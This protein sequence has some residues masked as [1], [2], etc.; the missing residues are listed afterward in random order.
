MRE[1]RRTLPSRRWEAMSLTWRSEL[2]V[3]RCQRPQQRQE[4]AVDLP[5]E[6]SDEDRRRV[7][8]RA[9]LVGLSFG[10]L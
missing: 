6:V 5:K 2:V 7:G 8:H 3:G 1:R 4:M 9:L 10:L